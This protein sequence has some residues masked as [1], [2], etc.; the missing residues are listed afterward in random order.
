ADCHLLARLLAPVPSHL[1]RASHRVSPRAAAEPLLAGAPAHRG[2]AGLLP[3]RRPEPPERARA[4]CPP[5]RARTG[6]A[7]CRGALRVGR[8]RPGQSAP[9][10]LRRLL[11]APEPARQSAPRGS[12]RDPSAMDP[13]GS[14]DGRGRMSATVSGPDAAAGAAVSARVRAFYEEIP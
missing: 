6:A 3:P 13:A 8:S 11:G 12:D 10:A 5:E 1:R 2:G 4:L 9:Y 14:G 7:R